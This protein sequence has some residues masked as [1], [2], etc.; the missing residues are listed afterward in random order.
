VSNFLLPEES[1]FATG[2]VIA[3]YYQRVALALL[4]EHRTHTLVVALCL[5]SF[6]SEWAVRLHGTHRRGYTIT[7]SWVGTQLW[8]TEDTSRMPSVIRQ[9]VEVTSDFA[10]GMVE[11]FAKML[12]TVANMNR[13]PIGLDGVSYHFVGRHP[14]YG[15]LC[16]RTWS[17]DPSTTVGQFVAAIDKLRKYVCANGADA[18]VLQTIQEEFRRCNAIPHYQC[19]DNV[20]STLKMQ[21]ER[22]VELHR[23]S[24]ISDNEL[25][26]Q[27]ADVWEHS[28]Y[29]RLGAVIDLVSCIPE[30]VRKRIIETLAA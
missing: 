5:P 23:D 30:T 18:L 13:S 14:E 19:D 21:T 24:V 8:G 4:P 7:V 1:P 16:G 27:L 25:V 28:G 2:P 6:D 9:A 11:A 3:R 20:A 15:L 26:S 12:R 10:N 29:P 22:L 17:P